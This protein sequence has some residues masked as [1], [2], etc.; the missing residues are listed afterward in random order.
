MAHTRI[1]KDSLP[2][3]VFG[4]LLISGL[5]LRLYRLTYI[6]I[7][8][9]EYQSIATIQAPWEQIIRGAYPRE[10]HPPLYFM[11]LKVWTG[12]SGE[13]E[14]AM[15]LLSLLFS[16]GSMLLIHA[17]IRQLGGGWQAASA[18]LVL[19]AF[20]PTYVFMS[21]EVRMYGA[22][23]FFT[24]A[25]FSAYLEYS[26][27]SSGGRVWLCA[28]SLACLA[29]L[30]THYLGILVPLGIAILSPI[31]FCKNRDR[32]RVDL[33][34][35]LLISGI[36]YL[37]GLVF[38]IF[39]QVRIYLLAPNPVYEELFFRPDASIFLALL[40]GSGDLDFKLT[41]PLENISLLNV[42]IGI[43]VLWHQ[44]KAR[45]ASAIVVFLLLAT[46]AALGMGRAG[47][48]LAPRYLT[49]VMV[50]A[51]ILGAFSLSPLTGWWKAANL[52]GVVTIGLYIYTS[53]AQTTSH[54]Y[55]SP[56][57][58]AIAAA[59]QENSP[60][61][62]PVVVMG[63]DAKPIYFY[64]RNRRFMS[65]YELEAEL[66][67]GPS[68]TSYLIVDTQFGQKPALLSKA[69]TLIDIPEK[70][71]RILR[72]LPGADMGIPGVQAPK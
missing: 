10:L 63:W 9:D 27:S 57:W 12:I 49:H 33:F 56:D 60:P 32:H 55:F 4:G 23:L 47:I 40:S 5:A 18:G 39:Q 1:Q 38:V 66:Q 70:Q 17:I 54:E 25:A 13:S 14:L 41:N 72:Y 67:I 22:L 48:N 31:H 44:Q 24:L 50:F 58:R 53:V 8:V 61:E 7:W 59:I 51:L 42:V 30:Y 3:I 71:V 29:A 69:S 45:I 26:K 68:H 65:S 46:L 19:I 28:T 34:L 11:L 35:A 37:P 52:V 16:L 21:I 43:L 20:H 62:E 2:W 64:L 6:T 36:L 15:R